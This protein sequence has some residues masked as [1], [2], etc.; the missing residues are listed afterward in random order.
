LF[1]ECVSIE[2]GEVLPYQGITMDFTVPSEVSIGQ[3]KF[4]KYFTSKFPS[5]KEL[6]TSGSPVFMDPVP[7]GYD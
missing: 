6:D 3:Y 1:E 7:E 5:V 4:I 2:E